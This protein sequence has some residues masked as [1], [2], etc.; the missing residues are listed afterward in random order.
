MTCMAHTVMLGSPND[1]HTAATYECE[2]DEPPT[3][4][5]RAGSHARAAGYFD[6]RLDDVVVPS[7]PARLVLLHLL[8]AH[9]GRP[10]VAG[11]VPAGCACTNGGGRSCGARLADVASVRGVTVDCAGQDD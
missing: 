1:S 2:A 5:C 9:A 3:G 11:G 10:S 8:G 6:R 4:C 7:P